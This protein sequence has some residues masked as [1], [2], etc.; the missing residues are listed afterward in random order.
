LERRKIET[1]YREMTALIRD[2]E[3]LLKSPKKMR[4][5]VA[6]ELLKVK[7]LYGDR[8]RTQIVNLSKNGKGQT[9]TLTT[10]D[11][12]PQQQ[13]WVGVTEDGLVSRTHEDKQPKHSGNDA[14]AG[15]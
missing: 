6:E 3:T 5:V 14:P 10:R 4:G 8:R 7:E 1:E 15:W 11:L 12:L 13:M 9:K 2:L